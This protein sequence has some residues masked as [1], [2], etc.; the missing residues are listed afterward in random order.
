MCCLI[1]NRFGFVYSFSL[2]CCFFASGTTDDD[3][4]SLPAY[5]I[6]LDEGE[7]N[8]NGWLFFESNAFK[9]ISVN[10]ALTESINTI[11]MVKA[12][13]DV[14]DIWGSSFN[15]KMSVSLL[16]DGSGV[17]VD[18]P[19]ISSFLYTDIDVIFAAAFDGYPDDMKE[20]VKD[21]HGCA[22]NAIMDDKR[23]K[24]MKYRLVFPR[25]K[26]GAK[27]YW[28]RGAKG[29]KL[30]PFPFTNEETLT[31]DMTGA[32]HDAYFSKTLVFFLI[33]IDKEGRVLKVQD[34]DDVPIEKMF[35]NFSRMSVSKRRNR[36]NNPVPPA[37]ATSTAGVANG[38]VG[39]GGGGVADMDDGDD[40]D[41]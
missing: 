12:I 41:F 32:D 38:T 24:R 18:E 3:Y 33:P 36:R 40:D 6:N 34:D 27:G 31:K 37:A 20:A 5:K 39:G 7:Q 1:R 9:W 15:D 26:V 13:S 11:V 35:K 23:R 29:L 14:F 30:T 28:N 17:V 21:A 8:V 25:D 10:G 2:R 4:S 16:P 22:V 19:S